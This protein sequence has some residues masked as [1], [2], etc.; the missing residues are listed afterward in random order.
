MASAP[1]RSI[2]HSLELLTIY[3]DSL[4]ALPSYVKTVRINVCICYG[5]QI[6]TKQATKPLSTVRH[7]YQSDNTSLPIRF[8]QQITFTDTYICRLQREALVMFEVY[9]TFHD[10]YDTST[11]SN[12]IENFDGVSMRLIGWCSQALFDDRHVLITGERYLGMLNA[13]I[14]NR[15][16]FYSLRNTV[17]RDCSI[18]TVRFLNQPVVWPEI[19]A[20]NDL[21][22][23]NFTEINRNHQE[24]LSGLLDRTIFLLLDHSTMVNHET[25][26][27]NGKQSNSNN[28][29][30]EC[31]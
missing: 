26:G 2:A 22:A 3:V 13:S 1:L 21:K 17:E 18:L 31:R 24:I 29:S 27:R 6:Y 8:D 28:L 16:G 30:D 4:L 14:M 11:S 19:E 7:A 10:D 20:R 25:H 9:T 15:T 23:K 5:N 12:V